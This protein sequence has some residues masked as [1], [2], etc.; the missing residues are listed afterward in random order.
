VSVIGNP[1]GPSKDRGIYRTMDGGKT[2]KQIFFKH[3]Q[4]GVIDLVM[5]EDDPNTLYASTFEI[6]RRTWI[7][8]S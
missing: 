5:C 6:L 3:E 2:W 7:L 4:A 8:G 1:F